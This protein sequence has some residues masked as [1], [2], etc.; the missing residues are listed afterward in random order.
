[1]YTQ[2]PHPN[3]LSVNKSQLTMYLF[4]FVK[5]ISKYYR[6]MLMHAQLPH[7]TDLFSKEIITTNHVQ[8]TTSLVNTIELKPSH[9]LLFKSTFLIVSF[10]YSHNHQPCPTLSNPLELSAGG[11]APMLQSYQ[12]E[13]STGVSIFFT[14]FLLNTSTTQNSGHISPSLSLIPEHQKPVSNPVTTRTPATASPVNLHTTY[15]F[16]HCYTTISPQ[17]QITKLHKT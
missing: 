10:D 15:Y 14:F 6:C 3:D 2:L 4:L 13:F 12:L 9:G 5:T 17:P 11:M 8:C 1:M 16:S 7:P